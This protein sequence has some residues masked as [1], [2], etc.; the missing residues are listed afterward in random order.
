MATKIDC[1]KMHDRLIYFIENASL[2]TSP[3]IRLLM[4]DC[5]L[6]IEAH[7]ALLDLISTLSSDTEYGIRKHG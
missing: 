1:A 2:N 4:M 6:M 7:E 3:Q 5:L